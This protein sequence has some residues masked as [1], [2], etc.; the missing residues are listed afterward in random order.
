MRYI[1]QTENPYNTGTME[2]V[3]HEAVMC[4]E[5]GS[6]REILTFGKVWILHNG[7][8]VGFVCPRISR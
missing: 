4:K 8:F 3:I 2:H 5:L 1:K 7:E 6:K